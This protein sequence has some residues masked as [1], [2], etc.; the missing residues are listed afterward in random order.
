MANPLRLRGVHHLARV[1]KHLEAS[2]SFYRDL[3]G[4]EEIPRPRFSFDGAWLYAYG[5]QIHLIVNL[6]C[7]DAQGPIDTRGNHLALETEDVETV[8]AELKRREVTYQLNVQAS[9][10][11]KQLFFRDPDG[12]QIEIAQYGPTRLTGSWD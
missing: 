1:T 11:L 5:V 7:P 12:H 9:T 2:R 10:G 8:E 4:F 6:Q 3:L